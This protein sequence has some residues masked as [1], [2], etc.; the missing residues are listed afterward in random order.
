MA[1]EVI[2]NY[3]VDLKSFL[4]QGTFGYVMKAKHKRNGVA[5]AVKRI[6]IHRDNIYLKRELD[7]LSAVSNHE[8]IVSLLD[9]QVKSG[10]LWLIMDFCDG[11]DINKYLR[12]NTID[13]DQMMDFIKQ[14]VEAVH[15]MHTLEPEAVIHRDLKAQNVLIKLSR[16]GPILKV[17]F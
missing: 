15:Y 16:D 3:V 5:A 9:W 13:D 14:I 6:H 10:F 12:K 2:G 1:F 11:G 17:S 7:A 4:G 8:N